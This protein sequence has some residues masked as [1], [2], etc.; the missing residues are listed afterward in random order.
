MCLQLYIY[1]YADMCGA[2]VCMHMGVC[3][4]ICTNFLFTD[5]DQNRVSLMQLKIQLIP[6]DQ[7]SA[8]IHFI[9][10]SAVFLGIFSK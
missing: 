6:L 8:A 7:L 5:A 10:S 2:Y 4:C 1:L 9:A 3:V